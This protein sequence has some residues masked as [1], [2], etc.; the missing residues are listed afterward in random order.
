MNRTVY[1]IYTSSYNG[2][3]NIA[4]YTFPYVV[5]NYVG[6]GGVKPKSTFKPS[7]KSCRKVNEE[8]GRAEKKGAG[9]LSI[10]IGLAPIT[11]PI[12]PDNCRYS[13]NDSAAT[14]LQ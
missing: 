4:D 12:L 9:H 6:G 3:Y 1:R 14:I 8:E 7:H 5:C 2:I 11:T 13:A 10:I